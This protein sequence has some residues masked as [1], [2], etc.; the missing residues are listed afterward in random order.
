MSGEKRSSVFPALSEG[1]FIQHANDAILCAQ[2]FQYSVQVC[3]CVC[4]TRKS[5]N[6]LPELTGE[7]GLS[8][9]STQCMFV[10]TT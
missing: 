10:Y 9:S 1:L 8:I 2:D 4:I 3:V 6:L 5:C 7:V